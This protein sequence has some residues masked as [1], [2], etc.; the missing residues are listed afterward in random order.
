MN[1]EKT[2]NYSERYNKLPEVEVNNEIKKANPLA[3]L[4]IKDTAEAITKYGLQNYIELRL[5]HKHFK[6]EANHNG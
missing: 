4:F 1:S 3:E 2:T 5:I 6:I